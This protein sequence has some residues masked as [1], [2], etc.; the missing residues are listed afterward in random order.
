M[1]RI[2]SLSVI[3]AA[4]L[5]ASAANAECV[6][7]TRCDAAGNCNEVEVCDGPVDLAEVASDAVQPGMNEGES[8]VTEAAALDGPGENCRTVEICNTPTLVCD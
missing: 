4:L 5:W 1:T 3:A 8:L 6:F 7:Q 2:P